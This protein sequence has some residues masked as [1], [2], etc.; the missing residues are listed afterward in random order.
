MEKVKWRNQRRALGKV[1]HNLCDGSWGT[2]KH[3]HRVWQTVRWGTSMPRDM[4]SP[5][6]SVHLCPQSLWSSR[7]KDDAG[8]KGGMSQGTPPPYSVIYIK[9]VSLGNQFCS[10]N[11]CAAILWVLWVEF[12]VEFCFCIFF[13]PGVT[14]H[15]WD[16]HIW[17]SLRKETGE[18][19]RVVHELSLPG[20]IRQGCRG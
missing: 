7:D 20:W 1:K 2:E 11:A 14:Q 19:A 3:C 4:S 18:I 5:G 9:Y 15:H 10:V 12:W 13:Q 17:K 16:K 8:N 6:H